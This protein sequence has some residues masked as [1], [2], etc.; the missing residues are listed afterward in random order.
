M[1]YI[2]RSIEPDPCFVTMNPN[3][4]SGC[5]CGAP[6]EFQV[7][8]QPRQRSSFNKGAV[9]RKISYLYRSRRC[10]RRHSGDH[11]HICPGF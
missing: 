5:G 9:P 11:E 8:S 4:L 3:D 7:I 10:E 1:N 6:L 2:D